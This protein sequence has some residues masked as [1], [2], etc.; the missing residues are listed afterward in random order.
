M[1]QTHGMT[2][3]RIFCGQFTGPASD[4][5]HLQFAPVQLVPGDSFSIAPLSAAAEL[6]PT[7]YFDGWSHDSYGISEGALRVD[8]PPINRLD[9][10]SLV[11]ARHQLHYPHQSEALER[12]G[13]LLTEARRAAN[14]GRFEDAAWMYAQV[15]ADL[16]SPAEFGWESKEASLILQLP[17][18]D[19]ICRELQAEAV[20]GY[21]AFAPF[22]SINTVIGD[23][24]TL[25]P[26][27]EM[28]LGALRS[29]FSRLKLQTK[30]EDPD[31]DSPEVG[32]HYILTML[33][34]QS[35][36]SQMS[37]GKIDWTVAQ[38][39]GEMSK[40]HELRLEIDERIAEVS[41]EI[42]RNEGKLGGHKRERSE[43]KGMRR[44]V[45]KW[46]K[47][48]DKKIAKAEGSL[49]S[50]QHRFNGLLV[51]REP[52]DQELSEL[53]DKRSEALKDRDVLFAERLAILAEARGVKAGLNGNANWREVIEAK[54]LRME[55][56]L[57]NAR[58]VEAAAS[59]RH[60][61]VTSGQ[62]KDDEADTSIPETNYREVDYFTNAERVAREIIDELM[63]R[64]ENDQPEVTLYAQMI[65]IDALVRQVEC[66]Y[67]R[68][69]QKVL[70]ALI[71]TL[72]ETAFAI[73]K[74][75]TGELALSVDEKINASR[76]IAE[77][78]EE[79]ATVLARLGVI[80][81]A[82]QL[83]HFLTTEDAYKDTPAA[84]KLREDD[85]FKRTPLAQ[86]RFGNGHAP[87]I[88]SPAEVKLRHPW[89]Q[90]VAMQGQ[91]ALANHYYSN[92]Y[93]R[94]LGGGIGTAAGMG[95]EYLLTGTMGAGTA[96]AGAG[97]AVAVNTG[98]RLVNA[99][100]HSPGAKS[101]QA[102]GGYDRSLGQTARDFAG[103]TFIRGT[104]GMAGWFL[105]A[106]AASMLLDPAHNDGILRA[107]KGLGA[108]WAGVG[109][110]LGDGAGGM[111]HEALQAKQTMLHAS[112][113]GR[114]QYAL[115]A[116]SGLY[117]AGAGALYGSY[118]MFPHWREH[119]KPYLKW[120]APGAAWL[121]AH[122]TPEIVYHSYMA[123]SGATFLAYM[124]SRDARASLRKTAKMWVPGSIMAAAHL[125]LGIRGEEAGT[126]DHAERLAISACALGEGALML[127]LSGTVPLPGKL[128]SIRA[129]ITGAKNGNGKQQ[130]DVGLLRAMYRAMRDDA[131]WMN[132]NAMAFSMGFG[133]AFGGEIQKGYLPDHQ[134]LRLVLSA[135]TTFGIL[136][137]TLLLSGVAK[138]QI[139]IVEYMRQSGED[140]RGMGPWTRGSELFLSGFDALF[141]TGYTKN[142]TVR[143]VHPYGDLFT[144]WLRT[145]VGHDGIIGHAAQ[146]VPNIIMGNGMSTKSSSEMD[147]T[148]WQLDA[149]HDLSQKHNV[150][151]EG[152]LL[153]HF[154][155]ASTRWS[156][157]HPLL[158]VGH[159]P[160]SIRDVLDPVTSIRY[161]SPNSRPNFPVR[162][163]H[164]YLSIFYLYVTGQTPE[165]HVLKPQNLRRMLQEVKSLAK[166][167]RHEDD[168]RPIIR[169]LYMARAEDHERMIVTSSDDGV[170]VPGNGKKVNRMIIRDWIQ[171]NPSLAR[172]YRDIED[173]H[174]V[175]SGGTR[176][177]Q[178]AGVRRA[179]SE[180]SDEHFQRVR[181][182]KGRNKPPILAGVFQG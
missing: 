57:F 1:V 181:T 91:A 133:A 66:A 20:L 18:G 29:G 28:D 116:A 87:R 112:L 78:L 19:L 36:V 13:F 163:D 42:G 152:K 67:R 117:L 103:L 43:L 58:L 45:R 51:D 180:S 55:E 85:D 16:G 14:E 165:P 21:A 104:M 148:Q 72:F 124:F 128:R 162:V 37:L 154:R 142:R 102:V 17:E 95:L 2:Y 41:A 65:L 3:G 179:L 110:Q 151:P 182:Y 56:F 92:R 31:P 49:E 155:Q 77:K 34:E 61:A 64:P 149:P 60:A 134:G 89:I 145:N 84:N 81:K 161:S 141:R 94:Y 47:Y 10:Q 83:G 132:I 147:G 90:R 39:L 71:K 166:D 130:T 25:I 75:H 100:R 171:A 99:W 175:M 26:R 114:V 76:M 33:D 106:Y 118:A 140:T 50:L 69:D 164:K 160:G 4:L 136:P 15:R 135:V 159:H 144:A 121:A 68:G 35:E 101:A 105:P 167:P 153:T 79:V 86:F 82:V 80:D 173:E 119:I 9:P 109:G 40:L 32:L 63:L 12:V 137:V 123:A 22:D 53:R 8:G 62:I 27:L 107:F 48:L 70:G 131:N 7:T 73:G 23:L 157:A 5:S 54:I 126:W 74:D 139:P 97:G 146:A 96:V 11:R 129:R 46:R 172:F 59:M 125:G 111:V 143:V 108:A 98:I 150:N 24:S 113:E 169:M 176:R 127:I 38:L 158:F 52:V 138:G 6:L 156:F 44:W 170:A 93:Q 174:P 115:Q 178:M 122:A 120:F 168:M 30:R 177:Q 88:M